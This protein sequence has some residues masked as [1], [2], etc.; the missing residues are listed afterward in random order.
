[1]RFGTVLYKYASRSLTRHVRRTLI[2]MVG[3]GVGCAMSLIALSWMNGAFEMQVRAVAE[4]G[5]GHLMIV[6]RKWP[7]LREN[8]LRLSD[9]EESL[10]KVRQNP[11]VRACSARARANG[12]LAFGN[13]SS[14]V[15][16]MALQPETESEVNRV[17]SRSQLEGRYLYPE[18][19]DSIVIGKSLAK[20]L[21]V[22]LDDDLFITV[23]GLEDIHSAI[24]RI[25]GILETGSQDLDLSICH[26]TLEALEAITEIPGAGEIVILLK[27][28]NALDTV[29]NQLAEKMPENN[30]VITWKEVLPALAS[31]MQGDKA[32]MRLLTTIVIVVVALGIMSAQLTAVLERRQEFAILSALGMKGGQITLIVFVESL[33]IGVGGAL[34]ALFVGG[35]VSWYLATYGINLLFFNPEGLG[36]SNILLDPRIYGSFG[37]WLI[38]Y[39]LVI[40]ITAPVVASLYPAWKAAQIDPADALRTQ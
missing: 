25:V 11:G 14:G 9:W 15:Q 20:R 1:M 23:P 30:L 12:L 32:I 27:D 35:V 17:I 36:P 8:S 33:L 26:V 3:V 21:S 10:E 29:S 6:H 28:Y 13:R 22:E 18:E 31:G 5:S 40:S 34:V 19:L 2:S 16:I 38:T 7:D 4:S 24:L 37:S 39:A